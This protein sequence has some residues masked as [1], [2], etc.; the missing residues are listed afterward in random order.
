M[1]NQCHG[2]GFTRRCSRHRRQSDVK[3]LKTG[4]DYVKVGMFS[5][6]HIE[7]CLPQ[8]IHCTKKGIA[9]VAV[10]FADMDFDF[11][12]AIHIAKS[13]RLKGV[14]LGHCS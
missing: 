6:R 11:D 14:M 7:N 5:E 12:N 1:R 8:L 13:A 3:P 10:F 9:I 4:V 2:G